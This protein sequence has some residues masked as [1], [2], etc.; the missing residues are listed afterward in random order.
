LK[1]HGAFIFAGVKQNPCE[2]EGTM[3]SSKIRN[4]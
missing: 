1:D 2:D 4:K 3:I